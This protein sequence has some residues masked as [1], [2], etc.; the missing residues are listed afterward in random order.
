MVDCLRALG[1]TVDVST[2]DAGPVEV[3]VTGVAGRPRGGTEVF[4]RLSGTTSRFVTPVAA[5]ADGPV[6]DRR[7]AA[8]AG[9]AHG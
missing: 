8:D 3:R 6:R 5:L 1:A 4:T 2:P 7:P 9:P